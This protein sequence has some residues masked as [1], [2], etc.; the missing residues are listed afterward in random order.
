MT[1]SLKG[2]IMRGSLISNSIPM[3]PNVCL[4]KDDRDPYNDP[5]RFIRLVGRLKYLKV[6]KDLLHWA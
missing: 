5:K 4:I 2:M 1:L 6:I 3:I